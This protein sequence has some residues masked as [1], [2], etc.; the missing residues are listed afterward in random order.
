MGLPGLTPFTDLLHG[1]VMDVS[2][3][4]S[5]YKQP[6]Q[7]INSA[8]LDVLRTSGHILGKVAINGDDNCTWV[9]ALLEQPHHY[10]VCAAPCKGYRF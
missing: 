1:V 2:C 9:T 6:G 5:A 3:N 7:M 4:P 8:F 10:C